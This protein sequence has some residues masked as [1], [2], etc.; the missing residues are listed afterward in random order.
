[1]VGQA[2]PELRKSGS[3]EAVLV[4]IANVSRSTTVSDLSRPVQATQ[5]AKA[6]VTSDQEVKGTWV[7]SNGEEVPLGLTIA[8]L[9]FSSSSSVAIDIELDEGRER[10]QIRA[11]DQRPTV[12]PAGDGRTLAV[13]PYFIVAPKDESL[14]SFAS[15]V[16]RHFAV[17]H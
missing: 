17:G 3:V 16:R 2:C 6:L 4:E 5:V 14:K 9:P 8:H 1:M 10:F 12:L 11:E 7:S 13:T 15:C